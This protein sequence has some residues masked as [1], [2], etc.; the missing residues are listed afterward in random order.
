MDDE[1]DLIYLAAGPL[2]AVVVGMALVPLREFTIASNFAFVFMALTVVVAEFGGRRAAVATAIASALSLDFFLTQPY[3]RLTID[4]KHD[5]I[6]FLG[7]GAC[8]LIAAAFG[9][10]RTRAEANLSESRSHGEL[11]HR[12]MRHLEGA[13]P[14]T[15]ALTSLLTSAHASFPVAALVVRDPRGRVLA[16]SEGAHARPV[17]EILLPL[18]SLLPRDQAPS[19]DRRGLPLPTEGARLELLAG[20]RRTG[21][22]D[23]WG[24]GAPAGPESRQALSDLARLVAVLVGGHPGDGEAGR[25]A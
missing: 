11:L 15:T 8:G 13:G 24:N 2:A 22:L 7:L 14:A 4:D 17:P 18:D 12:A 16:A 10:R 25:A 9:T 5:L 21:W 20:N 3:L 19:A 6:A 1:D 23:L